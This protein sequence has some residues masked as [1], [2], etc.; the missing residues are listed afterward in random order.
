VEVLHGG[1]RI[2]LVG[3]GGYTWSE[4]PGA[5]WQ[6]AGTV[7]DTIA[8]A[9]NRS[10]RRMSHG[11]PLTTA[12]DSSV[13]VSVTTLSPTQE[14]FTVSVNGQQIGFV[15]GPLVQRAQNRTSECIEWDITGT[16]TTSC[17]ARWTTYQDSLVSNHAVSYSPSGDT[18]VLA[19]SRDKF[20]SYVST[21]IPLGTTSI[22]RH[23]QE[24]HSLTTDLYFLPI[25]G[26]TIR[27]PVQHTYRVETLGLSEDGMHL[28]AQT[29]EKYLYSTIDTGSMVSQF[30]K[31][32]ATYL[33]S[34]GTALFS[35][36]PKNLG[37]FGSVAACYP[38]ATFAP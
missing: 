27:G 29:R 20:D 11:M 3:G 34:D 32:R 26:G 19:I 18:I 2:R 10:K 23:G 1:K 21:I 25:R 28:V 36:A 9:T 5:H 4:G 8:N 6:T 13:S 31:C 7:A 24:R 30:N 35:T 37:L 22:R 16:P 17:Y 33:R 38:G 15:D 12:A 14:R